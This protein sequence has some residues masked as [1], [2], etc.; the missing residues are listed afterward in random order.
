MYFPCFFLND[1]S[2]QHR[3]FSILWKFLNERIELV[4]STWCRVILLEIEPPQ[5]Q[6][7]SL[8]TQS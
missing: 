4:T 7:S 2:S 1:E 6:I 3:V 8:V 5:V